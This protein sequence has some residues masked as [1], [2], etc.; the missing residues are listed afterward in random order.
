MT[1]DMN[2]RIKVQMEN[3]ELQHTSQDVR[4]FVSGQN[5]THRFDF[6]QGHGG[7]QHCKDRH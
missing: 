1:Q 2:K 5:N 6:R 3:R 7:N 4:H